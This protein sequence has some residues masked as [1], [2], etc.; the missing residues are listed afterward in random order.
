MSC[1]E[2]A[3]GRFVAVTADFRETRGL[4]F[5]GFFD[6]FGVPGSC[7]H[8]GPFGGPQATQMKGK[9]GVWRRCNWDRERYSPREFAQTG[10]MRLRCRLI[11]VSRGLS[12]C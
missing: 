1:S 12:E 6:I 3:A 2:D 9:S 11:P 8:I 5:R 10:M 4:V 7:S